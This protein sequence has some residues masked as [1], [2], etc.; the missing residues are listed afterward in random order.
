MRAVIGDKAL[1]DRFGF[2]GLGAWG[3]LTRSRARGK[4]G[5]PYRIRNR[6]GNLKLQE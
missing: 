4:D 2:E 1:R 3:R 5:Q 6:C